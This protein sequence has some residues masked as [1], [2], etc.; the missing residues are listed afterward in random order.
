MKSVVPHTPPSLYIPTTLPTRHP[1]PR[2][3]PTTLA[4]LSR[5]L[6]RGQIRRDHFHHIVEP[7][8]Q[9][10]CHVV[11][12]EEVCQ[13]PLK[14]TTARQRVLQPDFL[15]NVPPNLVAMEFN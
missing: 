15:P 11:S 5:P 8:E 14:S 3:P 12:N 13:H 9:A 1:I 4:H 6:S 10:A 7:C 2:I